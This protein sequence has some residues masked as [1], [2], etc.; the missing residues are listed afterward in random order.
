MTGRVVTVPSGTAGQQGSTN[1]AARILLSSYYWESDRETIT[2]GDAI[3]R[4]RDVNGYVGMTVPFAFA[5]GGR[6]SS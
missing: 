4:F 3:Q 5:G 2:L 6:K 1:T